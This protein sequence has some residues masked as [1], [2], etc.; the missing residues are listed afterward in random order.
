MK[1]RNR[2][3]FA[4]KAF[5]MKFPSSMRT[6]GTLLLP[7]TDFDYR[8]SVG[9]GKGSSI[10]MAC[11]LWLARVFPEAPMR[12]RDIAPDGLAKI[13]PNHRMQRLLERPNPFYSGIVMWMATLIDFL[14][15]GNAY[16]IKLRN[17]LGEVV[18]LWYVPQSMMA[19]ASDDKRPH[20][21]ITHYEYKPNPA[22][23]KPIELRVEDVVHFRYGVDEY[24]T[25][26]GLSPIASLY[27]EIFTDNEAA[28]F[29]ASLLKN[30]GVPGVVLSPGGD[31]MEATG[32]DLEEV[33][34]SFKRSFNGDNRGEPL[35]MRTK[36]DVKVLSFSPQQMDL[37]TL[38]RLPE[39][40]VT[41]VIG[42]AAVVVGF[43][44]GLD[45]STFANF[46]EAREAAFETFV[47]PLYRLIAADVTLQLL[48]DFEPSLWMLDANGQ[49]VLRMLG[50][51][52]PTIEAFFDTSDL[53]VLQEFKSRKSKYLT[54]Q[55]ENGLIQRF[56]ARL[57]LGRPVTDADKVYR[58][59]KNTLEV[60]AD[61][62]AVHYLDQMMQSGGG[63]FG[64]EG[65]DG[66]KPG[67]KPKPKPGSGASKTAE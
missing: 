13:R 67:A 53:L 51:D 57:D 58:I 52:D 2:L 62:G 26:K 10:V 6:L 40:R 29:A 33:K 42:I 12:V 44:A 21:F 43:G 37:R 48:P 28:N 14:I 32:D 27:R 65:N 5:S 20:I 4:F 18:Q 19:P 47:N 64:D 45:R 31:E 38:R 3:S 34:E 49:R 15:C 30:L 59:D 61:K 41:A 35:V 17:N 60:P 16:W 66:A 23:S 7:S 8:R 22:M 1:L 9:D 56:E 39:E 36:T 24:D 25:R 50:D 54:E 11:A 46:A 55:W 63:G